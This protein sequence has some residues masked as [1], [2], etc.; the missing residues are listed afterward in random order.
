MGWLRRLFGS[1]R[2]ERELPPVAPPTVPT[3]PVPPRRPASAPPAR[4]D[5]PLRVFQ[6]GYLSRTAPGVPAKDVTFAAIDLETTGL[7]PPT[8][9]VCEVAAVRFRGDGIVLDEYATLIDPQRQISPDA[10]E[11]NN[12][13]VEDIKGAPTFAQVWSDLLRMLSGSVV[14]AHNLPFE[15]TFLAAELSRLDQPFPP[16]VG[17]CSMLTCRAQLDGPTYGLQSMYR[18]ATGKWISDAHT[19]LGDCRALAVLIPWLIAKAPIPLRYYGPQPVPLRPAGDEQPGRIF[20]RAERLTRHADGYLGALAKRFP[21]TSVEYRV[22]SDAAQRYDDALDEITNDHAITGNEGWR[23]EHLARHAGFNQQRLMAAH[24][25]AWDRATCNLPVAEPGKLTRTQRRMLLELAHDLGY[26]DLAT[27]LAVDDADDDTPATRYLRGWRIG[28]DGDNEAATYLRTL[29]TSNG[30]SV[31]K[32]LTA[33]VRFVAATDPTATTPQLAQAR[34]LGLTVVP[35]KDGTT[36][37]TRAV[38]AAEMEA[39][40]R[41]REQQR[42]EATR[43]AEQAKADAHYRHRWRLVENNPEWGWA[44]KAVVVKLPH[45]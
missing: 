34:E 19:A 29:I 23:M 31:A 36:Q 22:D 17:L 27:Q 21:R 32:R 20:P 39:K 18:T 33:T 13:A 5:L 16:L 10:A 35:M 1:Q 11:C 42:W 43:A 14:V 45:S 8:H 44:E 28:V 7:L 12:I 9:R 26:P 4:T 6:P 3:R 25:T 40:R 2:Q 38:K 30:G 24:R 41:E 15:D 37:I